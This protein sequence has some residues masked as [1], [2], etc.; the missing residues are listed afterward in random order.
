MKKII[1]RLKGGIGNQLFSYAYAKKLAVEN[2]LDLYIDY[3]TGFTTADIYKRSYCLDDF[4]ITGIKIINPFE[5]FN[6]NI[7]R[8]ILCLTV[9][10]YF[11]LTCYYVKD[12]DIN[13]INKKFDY[14]IEGYWQS[15][16]YVNSIKNII[17]NEYKPKN[18]EIQ[19]NKYYKMINESI[20]AVGVHVRIGDNK[21]KESI[22]N[23]CEYYDCA[24]KKINEMYHKNT[25][26]IFTDNTFYAKKIISGDYVYI[27]NQGND[28]NDFQL[29][30]H[31]RH[32]IIAASTFSWWGAWLGNYDY[33]TVLCPARN[34]F[35][36]SFWDQ[37]ELID[38]NWI[39]I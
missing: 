22:S 29:Y 31:C 34:R 14:Y 3:Y 33:K 26:F 9:K 18:P 20:N 10:Y 38:K 27:K 35:K 11:L 5:S 36:N 23:L 8:R 30:R 2:D 7:I 37:P 16:K 6:N 1:V 28:I 19:N 12:E 13:Y 32:F 4:T 24:I 25:I 15:S 39:P 17:K 21:D